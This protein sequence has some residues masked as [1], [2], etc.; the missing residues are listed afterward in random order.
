MAFQVS[1]SFFNEPFWK[2]SLHCAP[3]EFLN[4]LKTLKETTTVQSKNN[5]TIPLEY[6]RH[7]NLKME[8]EKVRKQIGRGEPHISF[9]ITVDNFLKIL[10]DTPC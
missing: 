2:H 7:L 8:W 3:T 5:N 9:F 4:D 10:Y 1:L 6:L